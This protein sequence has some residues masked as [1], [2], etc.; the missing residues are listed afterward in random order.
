MLDAAVRLLAE[1]GF[2]RLTLNEVG[3]AAGYSRGLPAHYFGRKNDLLA[4]VAGDIVLRFTKR[5][6]RGQS[7]DQQAGIAALL[8]AA[9]LYLEGVS[10][11]PT[12]MRALLVILTEAISHPD[13]FPGIIELNR[14]SA[15]AL[16]GPIR[17]GQARGEIRADIDPDTQGVMILGQLCGVVA[18]WLMDR[19]TIDI[20]RLRLQFAQS[21]RR[22]VEA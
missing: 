19:E 4:A 3:E 20:D 15:D 21:L 2:A 17:A 22:S 1:K 9:D 14:A 8:R 11:D 5:V 7:E 16:A 10:K 18:Q 6:R 12:T 13:L